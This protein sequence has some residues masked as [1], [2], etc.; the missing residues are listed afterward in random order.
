MSQRCRGLQ[1]SGYSVPDSNRP[2]LVARCSR[3]CGRRTGSNELTT[4]EGSP[5]IV[6]NGFD[7]HSGA[8]PFLGN[9]VPGRAG[10][11]IKFKDMKTKI[12]RHSAWHEV[13]VTSCEAHSS[14]FG[15]LM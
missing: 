9:G 6:G 10:I 15:Q 14:R 1:Q 7:A 2:W 12:Y 5:P 8:S 4:I 11:V 13:C 3:N